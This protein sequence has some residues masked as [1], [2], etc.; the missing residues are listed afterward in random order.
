MNGF[1]NNNYNHC[2]NVTRCTFQ[3]LTN[4]RINSFSLVE[5]LLRGQTEKEISREEW[6]FHLC[7]TQSKETFIIW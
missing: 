3:A 6:N 1:W 7:N 4:K 2:S 5:V